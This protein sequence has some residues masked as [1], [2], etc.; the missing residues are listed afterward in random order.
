MSIKMIDTSVYLEYYLLTDNIF[1]VD[2]HHLTQSSD[3]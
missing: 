2:M 3:V 1:D